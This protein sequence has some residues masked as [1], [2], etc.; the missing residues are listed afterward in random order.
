MVPNE[1]TISV[2]LGQPAVG[3]WK[4]SNEGNSTQVSKTVYSPSTALRFY[5]HIILATT[6]IGKYY[7]Y[8][9]YFTIKELKHR[10]FSRPT[11]K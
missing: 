6:P 10:R 9:P 11:R 4:C 2:H 8:H 3:M 7:S 1:V 5:A